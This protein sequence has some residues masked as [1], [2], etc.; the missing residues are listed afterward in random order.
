M[1]FYAHDNSVAVLLPIYREHVSA[2]E[3]AINSIAKQTYR[4]I[5]LVVVADDP[6][7]RALIDCVESLLDRIPIASRLIVNPENMGLSRSLNLALSS[8]DAPYVC[9]MDAD[10]FSHPLRVERQLEYLLTNQL[11][12]IGCYMNVCSESGDLLYKEDRLPVEPDSI[13]KALAYK[14]CVMHPTWLGKREV[15]SLGYRQVP[16]AEDLDFLIRAVL[17]GYSLGNCPECL[18]DY[19]LSTG[20]VSRNNQYRQFL[21]QDILTREYRNHRVVSQ[22]ALGSEVERKWRAADDVRYCSAVADLNVM[23]GHGSR[24]D[25]VRATT[26]VF[27][28]AVISQPF[29]KKILTNVVAAFIS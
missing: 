23:L 15:F 11:D 3:R 12:L 6:D 1:P 5:N 7:N 8:I 29:R 14:N 4:D 9:R 27:S 25:R 21:V 28:A 16:L 19:T 24:A 2:V 26:R 20:S 18:F 17:A 13:K 22:R 10:D